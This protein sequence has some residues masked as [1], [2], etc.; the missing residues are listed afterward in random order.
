[1][2]VNGAGRVRAPT[3]K[4]AGKASQAGGQTFSVAEEAPSQEIAAGAAP[5]AITAVDS[6]LALQE[7]ADPQAGR[8]KAVKRAYDILDTLETIRLGLISGS[9]P[10]TRLKALINLV[11]MRRESFN[12]PDLARLI[13]EVDLRA[14]VEIAKLDKMTQ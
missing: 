3:V 13:D 4:R 11:E 5:S 9:L 1:M 8:R 2:K 14:R 6:L 10:V 12:D 7:I